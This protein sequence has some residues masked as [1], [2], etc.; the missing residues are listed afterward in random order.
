MTEVPPFM[1]A[2]T[3]A[4]TLSRCSSF[5]PCAGIELPVLARDEH[6]TWELNK[7]AVRD[8]A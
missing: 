8:V 3:A 5:R 6:G 7:W 4:M 1:I 2:T